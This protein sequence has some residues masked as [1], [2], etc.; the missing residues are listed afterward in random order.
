MKP[1]SSTSDRAL[2]R[3]AALLWSL[4]LGLALA[5][6]AG[7]MSD[8][9][10]PTCAVNVTYSPDPASPSA[11]QPIRAVANVSDYQG[12]ARYKWRVV[13]DEAEVP[14]A[15][16]DPDVSSI[17]FLAATPG[18]YRV[19][20][21]VDSAS[22]CP[23]Y[24]GDVNVLPAGAVAR[25][26]RLRITPPPGSAS[27]GPQD[28]RVQLF[29]GVDRCPPAARRWPPTCASRPPAARASSPRCRPAPTA[30]WI[31]A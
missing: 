19:E 5:A 10:P 25:A 3:G 24:A 12:I 9:T 27:T 11:T 2:V 31:R 1:R 14:F 17:E 20:L 18:V 15:A 29:G 8:S 28:Q 4:G 6:C 23:T 26:Y 13:R 7:D 21:R 22:S 16:A 30:G